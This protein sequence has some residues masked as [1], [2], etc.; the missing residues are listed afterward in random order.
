MP[1]VDVF[2][3]CYQYGAYLEEC[4]KSVLTQQVPELRLL[5]IDNASTDGSPEIAQRIAAADDRV[6]VYLNEQNRG[7][8]DSR[9]RAID[10]ARADYFVILDADDVLTEG[11][12]ARG[13]AFLDQ[14]P[15]VS[16][17]YGVEGRLTGGLLDQGRCD[18][19]TTRWNV[20]S[21]GEFIAR[22]CWD[23]FCD[24]GAP[25]VIV[26][27]ATQKAAGYYRESLARTC[28]F[29]MYLRLAMLGDVA[30]TNRVS[31]IRRIHE[32]QLSNPYH[33]DPIRDF[34][35]HEAAFGSFFAH[36]GRVLSNAEVLQSMSRRKMGDYV[37]WY[38]MA[39]RLRGRAGVSA[40]MD[41][42]AARRALPAWLPPLT[43]LL[44]K[45]WL[46]SLWRAGRRVRYAPTPLP[47]SYSVP[48]YL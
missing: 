28:D 32:A 3:P 15:E 22:T 23:S 18:A 47:S 17:L 12:L 1:G 20:V 13:I 45:R 21:G 25:A 16:F 7:V 26:R 41:F 11:A 34:E 48:S 2:V 10:W 8:H 24:I 38:A 31:G 29:E 6:T 42:A 37:Y 9:N 27:T 4:A 30:N 33:L 43:F 36:E 5:I 46:R 44:K 35:E 19:K 14:H 40:A 39:Q